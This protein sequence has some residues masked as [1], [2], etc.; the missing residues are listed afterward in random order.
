MVA[1][2]LS[3]LSGFSTTVNHNGKYA[4][5]DL[6][7]LPAFPT[8]LSRFFAVA[9]HC[10]EV[11]EYGEQGM[12]GNAEITFLP[13]EFTMQN[14]SPKD[15]NIILNGEWLNDNIINAAQ[16]LMKHDQ[17]LATACRITTKP[18]ASKER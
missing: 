14:E 13:I 11:V 3:N 10:W 8:P 15:R 5:S 18:I 6:Y 7:D 12:A 16:C 1:V 17:D 2:L 9:R 4:L